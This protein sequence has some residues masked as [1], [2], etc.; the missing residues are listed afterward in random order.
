LIR[1]PKQGFS[2]LAGK[3]AGILHKKFER[4]ISSLSRNDTHTS[5]NTVTHTST[6]T[7]TYSRILGPCS[8]HHAHMEAHV[9]AHVQDS[10]VSEDGCAELLYEQILRKYLQ[11]DRMVEWFESTR[12]S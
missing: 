6:N 5:I 3:L 8:H 7:V 2:K 9:Q 10:A 4:Q 1:D 11:I 12:R